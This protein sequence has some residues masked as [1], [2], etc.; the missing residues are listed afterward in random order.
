MVPCFD[1]SFRS[2]LFI[3]Q[4]QLAGRHV[5]N[6]PKLSATISLTC[7]CI[8]ESAKQRQRRIWIITNE[9]DILIDLSLVLRVDSYVFFARV[10]CPKL[11]TKSI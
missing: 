2:S 3:T 6:D 5:G 1:E 7:K 4:L 9:P 10:Y 8:S 11:T